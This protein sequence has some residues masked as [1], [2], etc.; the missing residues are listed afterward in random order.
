MQGLAIRLWAALTAPG[1]FRRNVRWQLVGSATQMVLGGLV[2]LLI[3]RGLGASQFGVF[4]LATG[5]ANVAIA[6]AE[7][8]MQDVAAKHFWTLAHEK[9]ASQALYFFDFLVIEVFSKAVPCALLAL[10]SATVASWMHLPPNAS[11]LIAAAAIGGYA[12]KIGVGLSTGLLRVLGRS[13]VFVRCMLLEILLRATGLGAA[14]FFVGLSV[15]NCIV[16]QS[17]TGFLC[18]ALQLAL[19]A[20]KLA[21]LKNAFKAWRLRAA[22]VR[23]S[24]NAKLM[25]FNYLISVTDILIKDLDVVLLG[26]ILTTSGVGIY[27]M[28]KN[29]AQLAW[30]AI[31][32]FTLSLM[33]EI[34]RMLALGE[35]PAFRRMQK[36]SSAWLFTLAAALSTAGLVVLTLWGTN[37]LGASYAA[38]PAVAASMVGAIILSAPLVWGHPLAVALNRPELAVIGSGFGTVI[39][40]AGI[41]LFAPRF[42]PQGAACAWALGFVAN[43][44]FIAIAAEIALRRMVHQA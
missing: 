3:G 4:A 5:L 44:L 9:D 11:P 21:G 31:D 26:T 37:L 43:F 16:I 1:V 13:D 17:M 10:L 33:P 27:R 22:I 42:G 7:P 6:L 39:G 28:A 38:V 24:E 19:A 40:V 15:W 12:T 35:F 41:L 18:N 30:R 36:L 25:A 8:R 34:N 2:L 32:P 29:A 23:C 20:S 14:Y